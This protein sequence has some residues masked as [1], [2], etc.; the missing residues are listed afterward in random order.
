MRIKFFLILIIFSILTLQVSA[1]I[2]R[3]SSFEE[4]NKIGKHPDFPLDGNYELTQDIDASESR[5][6]NDGQGFKPIG[7]FRSA[8][9]FDYM[10]TGTFDGKGFVIKDLYINRPTENFVGLFG[11]VRNGEIK[12]FGFEDA[13]IVGNDRVGALVGYMNSSIIIDCFSTITASYFTGSV[14]GGTGDQIGGLVGGIRGGGVSN[15]YF[16]GDVS[17]ANETVG[18]L[19][20]YSENVTIT[21]CY[22]KGNVYGNIVAGGLMGRILGSQVTNC[23]STASVSGERRLGGLVGRV[24]S[25]SNSQ[26]TRS[27]I[28]NCYSTGSVSGTG[29]NV[30]GLIGELNGRGTITNSYSAGLVSGKGNNIGGFIGSDG[31]WEMFLTVTNCFW[32]IE[33]SKQ[34]TTAIGGTGLLTAEM[35]QQVFYTGWDFNTIWQ[36]EEDHS[37]P[38]LSSL[39]KPVSVI[40]SKTTRNTPV[41]SMPLITVKNKTLNVKTVSNSDLQIRLFDMRGKTLVRF[42]TRGSGSNS[43]SLAK[44]PAGRY[45]IETRENRK[46]VEVS[47]VIIR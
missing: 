1:E 46:R 14:S 35:K 13:S 5:N 21:N 47:A 23:Y 19:V 10:F 20:G 17:G 26:A 38:Y 2:I 4:L 34:T 12:S 8:L 30:G 16:V 3:I 18:G 28:T 6:M 27:S 40:G 15:S 22:S 45:L 29:D 24:D 7:E 44:I 42:N 11:V 39:G 43:F 9:S 37:Y 36:I 25:E 41:T 33:T 32:D 31:G